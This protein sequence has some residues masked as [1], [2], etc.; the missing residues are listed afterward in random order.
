MLYRLISPKWTNLPTIEGEFSDAEIHK[1]NA[2]GYNVY[3]F[4]NHPSSEFSSPISGAD[5]DVFNMCFVDFDLKD[6]KYPSKDAFIQ[7]VGDYGITPSKVI[8]SGN[9][10][11]CYWK[12]TN[13]DAMSY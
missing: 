5:I 9:G 8:D 10:V 11:H 6:Q 12:V 2:D 3:C 1:Y 13:L 4:V 7:A